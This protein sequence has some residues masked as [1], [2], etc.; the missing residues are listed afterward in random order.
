M[1]KYLLEVNY[2][3][4][5]SGGVQSKGGS[6]RAKAAKELS[7]HLAGRRNAAPRFGEP[8][9]YVVADLPD[10]VSAAAAA[11]TVSASGGATARTKVLLRA[12]GVDPGT[13]KKT[14]DGPL[15]VVPPARGLATSEFDGGTVAVSAR[16]DHAG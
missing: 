10:N 14:T 4:T 8:D 3:L 5:A 15:G 13:E 16:D 12:A 7:K 11:L 2:K 9:V 6:A 1:S